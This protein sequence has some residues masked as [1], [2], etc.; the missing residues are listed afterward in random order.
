[1]TIHQVCEYVTDFDLLTISSYHTFMCFLTASVSECN[2]QWFSFFSV[3]V[4]FYINIC[5][6]QDLLKLLITQV[7]TDIKD[8]S[9]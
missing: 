3:I 5:Y 6:Y 2:L 4:P 9:F 8:R 7:L 1:M